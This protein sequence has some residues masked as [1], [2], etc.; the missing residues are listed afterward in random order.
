MVIRADYVRSYRP[1]GIALLILVILFM[2]GASA[3]AYFRHL[4]LPTDPLE[5]L[6]LI[7]ND[8]VGWSAQA[9]IFLV[10]FAGT[11]VVFGWIATQLPLTWPRWLAS[12][13]TL[14]FAAGFL[15]W[16]PISI[17]RLQLAAQVSELIRTYNPAAPPDL[18]PV[19]TF[20]AHTY[21][22][23]AAIA[24]MAAALALG[25]VLPILGWV[26]AGI[27][28]A[29]VLI[30]A[31]VWHDWPPFINYVWLLVMAIGLIRTG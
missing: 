28:V 3:A 21:C 2:I 16:S 12:G 5:K 4:P 20:W 10:V 19:S 22:V 23:L 17:H 29:S 15:L 30:A 18:M 27:A 11:T 14:L 13:A 25:D 9:I 7:A 26:V 1:M 31:F 24:L 8:R 6:T